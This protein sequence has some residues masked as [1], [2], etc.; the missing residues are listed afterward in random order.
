M[1]GTFYVSIFLFVCRHNFEV[2]AVLGISSL[3][4]SVVL[5]CLCV[6]HTTPNTKAVLFACSSD[7]ATTTG[8]P[9]TMRYAITSPALPTEP[10]MS[11]L[12]RYNTVY[13]TG[14][15]AFNLDF[16][17][18]PLCFRECRNHGLPHTGRVTES[19]RR[20]IM[21]WSMRKYL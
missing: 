20:E 16:K 9:K 1:F 7:W 19:Q 12:G 14:N 15:I 13:P 5:L 6:C 11:H 21:C 3:E 4:P 10:Q 2:Q 8:R 18:Q 17:F